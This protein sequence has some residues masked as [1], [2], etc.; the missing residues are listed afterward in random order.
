MKKVFTVAFLLVNTIVIGQEVHI[1]QRDGNYFKMGVQFGFGLGFNNI[2]LIEYNEFD[3][4]NDVVSSGD[5]SISGGGGWH[6][7]VTGEYVFNNKIGLGM[8]IGYQSSHLRPILDD[9]SVRFIRYTFIPTA[10]YLI[11]LNPE[12]NQTI[13]LG[14]GYG[15]YTGGKMKVDASGVGLEGNL[16]YDN[17]SGINLISEYEYIGPK[18]VGLAIGLRYYGL[19]YD[20]KE[21][22]GANDFDKLKGSGMDLYFGVTY[23]L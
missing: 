15:F 17:T 8:N 19:S 20:I 9:A 6:I 11:G 10:K 22:T 21:L 13:N 4:N 12:K 5:A 23:S 18:G 14:V 16:E 2:D 3:N 7:S 1:D